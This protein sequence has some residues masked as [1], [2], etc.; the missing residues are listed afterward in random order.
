MREVTKM[1]SVRAI[2]WAVAGVA[3]LAAC[4]AP[5]WAED[6]TW[7][8]AVTARYG[9]FFNGFNVG[10]YQFQSQFTGKAYTATGTASVSALF[11]AFTWKGDIASSG[12]FDTAKPHPANYQLSYK[13]KSKVVSVTLGFDKDAIK[14]IALIPDKKPS[15]EAVPVKEQDLKNVFDPMTAILAMTHTTSDKLCDRTI[16]IFDGKARFDL[17]MSYKGEQKVAEKAPS[18][19]PNKLVVCNVKYKPIS[20]HKPKDF[21]NPWVDYDKIEITLRPVPAAHTFVPYKITIPT[22]IGAAVMSA[23]QVNITANNVQIALTQ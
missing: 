23:E 18:G 6:G 4:A 8:V 5:A 15:P 9:L 12:S 19:Q 16:P 7:P 20:G 2:A 1:A 17:V 11:G 10:K 13:A 21:Q 22:T 14:K 3:A